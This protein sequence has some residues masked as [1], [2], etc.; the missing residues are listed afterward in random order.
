M[1]ENLEE[2]QEEGGRRGRGFKERRHKY[3]FTGGKKY[4]LPLRIKSESEGAGGK[5]D[6]TGRDKTEL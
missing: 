6:G 2:W 4:K 3:L 1:S 5:R